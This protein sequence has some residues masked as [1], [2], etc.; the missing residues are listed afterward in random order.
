[1]NRS[2]SLGRTVP[3]RVRR[4]VDA[5]AQEV[6]TRLGPR[7]KIIWFGSWVTGKARFN[8]D[9]DIAIETPEGLSMADY[10]ALWNWVDE[11]P[12]LY[13]IDLVNLSEVGPHFRQEILRQGIVL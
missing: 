10:A 2:A 1:M 6:H 5:I 7:V 9:I 12:T 3:D 4:L 8:S 11:L 13:S